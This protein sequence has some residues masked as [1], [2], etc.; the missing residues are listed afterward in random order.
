MLDWW[1]RYFNAR[2][3]A[4]V[5]AAGVMVG[6]CMLTALVV[7][8]V[9]YTEIDWVAYMQEVGGYLAGERNYLNLQGDTGP[10]VYPAGF[11]YV[12]SALRWATSGGTDIFRAQCLFAGL[13]LATLAMVLAVYRLGGN[14]SNGKVPF[15]VVGLLV[16]SKRIHSIFVLRM[17]ND[18][19]AVALGYLAVW[20]FCRGRLRW[21]AAAYSCAVSVKMNMFLHAPGVLAVFLLAGGW[22]ETAVCLAICAAVQVALGW[23]FLTAYPVE[24]LT[25]AFDLGRVFMYQWTVNFKFLPE[26]VFVSRPLSVALLL[27]TVAAWGLF[28][29]KWAVENVVALRLKGRRASVAAL[30]GIGKRLRRRQPRGGGGGGGAKDGLSSHFIV[31][32]IFVSNFVGVVFARSLHYQFYVWYFHMLP[33]LLW[34]ATRLPVRLKL[35][36]LLDIELAFNVFPATAWSSAMLQLGHVVLLGGLY[37]S[38]AP[39]VVSP[40]DMEVEGE[41]DGDD[42]DGS[43]GGSKKD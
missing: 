30:V 31:V 40:L 28:A 38:P 39:L 26:S 32:T 3:P 36:L 8:K 4:S 24:Y 25:R 42:D 11:V 18:C 9:A 13:Y 41:G 33:Y 37:L 29:R 27:A 12:F 10:L 20:L 23:P 16:L 5:V 14:R 17:F 43:G 6:D 22:L 7:R 1:V 35:L 19:V 34:H 15:V 21:G 2:I